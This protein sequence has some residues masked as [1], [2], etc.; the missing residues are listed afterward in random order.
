M[1]EEGQG[2]ITLKDNKKGETNKEENK[3]GIESKVDINNYNQEALDS[4]GN[5]K[6]STPKDE[7]LEFNK[8]DLYELSSEAIEKLGISPCQICQSNNY[9]IFIPETVY[10]APYQEERPKDETIEN[11]N[12]IQK[13]TEEDYIKPVKNQNIFLPVIICKQ[14]HQTCLICNISPHPDTLC[15]EKNFDYNNA[16]LKLNFIKET[17]P[18]KSNII[19]SMKQALFTPSIET[20]K[21]SCCSCK[22]CCKCLGISILLFIWTIITIFLG[23]VGVVIVGLY[24]GFQVLCCVYHC[25]YNM[26]CTT[27]VHDYDKGDH[28]LR[29]TTHYEDRERRNNEEAAN[30]A[31]NLNYCAA[32]GLNWTCSIISWG[33]KKICGLI[34]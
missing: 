21:E 32:G 19:E 2:I 23:V 8:N 4:K 12:Q 15:N 26:C 5:L 13:N 25:C 30:D 11:D 33:Y 20:N 16:I 17:F 28:I 3:N 1:T 7:Q 31:E 34:D 27:E 9:S 24:L 14:N 18:E 6:T 29:V 22:C 10:H